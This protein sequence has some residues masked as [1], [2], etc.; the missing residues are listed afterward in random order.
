MEILPRMISGTFSSD[1]MKSVAR[2]RHAFLISFLPCAETEKQ[3]QHIQ[4]FAFYTISILKDK[5]FIQ[6]PVYRSFTDPV[7]FFFNLIKLPW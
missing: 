4:R 6:K 5:Q 2:Q 1:Y 7:C 3:I